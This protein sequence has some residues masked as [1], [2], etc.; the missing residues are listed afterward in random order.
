MV[1][2]TI[3]NGT[4]SIVTSVKVGAD[5]LGA[6]SVVDLGHVIAQIIVTI[7]HHLVRFLKSPEFNLKLL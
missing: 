4:L 5:A 2:S 7:D 6:R 1:W 3:L